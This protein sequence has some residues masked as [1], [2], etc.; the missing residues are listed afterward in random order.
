MVGKRGIRE[1]IDKGKRARGGRWTGGG[2]GTGETRGWRPTICDL[3]NHQ[4]KST[5]MISVGGR[6]K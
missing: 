2:E 4:L 1:K 3:S 5:L 6:T